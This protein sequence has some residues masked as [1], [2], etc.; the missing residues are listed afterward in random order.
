MML[1]LNP[2]IPVE[3]PKGR[4]VAQVLIYYGL[5]HNLIWVTALDDS[6]QVWCFQNKDIRLQKNITS[7]RCNVDAFSP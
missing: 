7:G 6:G 2:P 1:Q 3:T 5:E 4:G